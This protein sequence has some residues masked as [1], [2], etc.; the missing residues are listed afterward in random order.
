MDVTDTLVKATLTEMDSL[1]S[2]AFLWNP[3]SYQ[4]ETRHDV[5]APP[6]LGGG[7]GTP[8]CVRGGTQRFRT[9]IL[10]DAGAGASGAE[11]LATEATEGPA[12]EGI[13]PEISGAELSGSDL[14]AWVARLERWS[15]PPDCGGMPRQVLFAWGTFRFRGFVENLFQEWVRFAPDGTPL[16]GW[17]DIVLR[18]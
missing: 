9:R 2:V 3:A 4:V 6:A 12:T 8:Q 18:T 17:L 15:A 14:R 16:R 5:V 10:L 7:G 1:E 13:R 11:G